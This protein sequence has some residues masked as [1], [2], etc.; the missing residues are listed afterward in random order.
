MPS[1]LLVGT[2]DGLYALDANGADR[3]LPGRSVSNLVPSD[4]GGWWAILDRRFVVRSADAVEWHEV[5]G[6]HDVE[7]ASIAPDRET[8]WIGTFPPH[9]YRLVGDRVERIEAFEEVAGKESWFT[10]WGGP[11]ETRSL[12]VNPDGMVFANVH[13]G[14]IPLSSDGG[15]SWQPTIDVQTDVHQVLV[16]PDDAELILAASARGLAVSRDGGNSWEVYREGVHGHYMSAVAVSGS[17]AFVT[18]STGS[19]SNARSAIYRIDL[20]NPERFERAGEGLPE[21]F[22]G[23]INTFCLDARDND[24]AFG[25]RDGDVF[26]A[27]VDELVWR[28]VADDLP[29]VQ[30]VRLRQLAI[31]Q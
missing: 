18:S 31:T 16:H 21:W 20:D 5:A 11:P 14:G 3:R 27:R 29:P 26:T 7:V 4:D 30:S 22:D 23:N 24:V 25:T 19:S 12:A 15:A 13:V 1:T 10:P 8:V 9:V 28:H 17:T 6:F 2:E